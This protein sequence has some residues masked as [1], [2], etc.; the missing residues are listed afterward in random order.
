[1]LHSKST[2]PTS[3][4]S[5]ITNM[6]SK[7][8]L[9][10]RVLLIAALMQFRT[11][12]VIGEPQVPCYFLFG[13]SLVDSGNN[14]RFV[15]A[16]KANYP[17]YGI[18][19]PQG[20]T[21]RFTNGLTTPDI[22]GQ[23]LGFRDF[24]PPYATVTN[25]EIVRG[26]NYASAGAGIRNETGMN[27]GERIIFDQQLLNHE[28]IVSRISALQNNKTFTNEYIQKCI[29][30]VNIGSDDYVNNYLMPN[31]YPTSNIFTPD[32]YAAV[33]IQRYSQQLTTLYNL[34]A[35]KVVLFGLGPIGCTPA[36]I[37][38]YGTN[39]KPCVESL[40]N[41]VKL[42]NDRLK[43]LVDDLN[44]GLSDANFT[45][46][47]FSG[48]AAPLN[49]V[50]NIAC[51]RIAGPEGLCIPNSNPCL[52]RALTAWYDGFHPSESS[53][54]ILAKRSYNALL[55]TDAYPYDISHLARL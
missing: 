29:Y 11:F 54:I 24:T 13:D 28:A 39:G 3:I 47:N 20:V 53:N 4:L 12:V 30:L 7:H 8:G 33:L 32:Q 37:A 18:D 48:I 22:I 34:G 9:L 55:P 46:I 15:K 5:S 49:A 51:C 2:S 44:N 36:A 19:F 40:N 21:G 14:N 17:P 43:P 10:F 23:L 27:V 26:V 38:K 25:E 1:M 16:E 6:A 45:F 31:N 42:F 52:V 35:R 50:P 41:L